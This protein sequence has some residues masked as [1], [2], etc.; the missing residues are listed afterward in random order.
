MR[1][2]ITVLVGLIIVVAAI[3]FLR[4]RPPVVLPIGENATSTTLEPGLRQV[5][6]YFPNT[7][8]DPETDCKTVFPVKRTVQDVP[9]IGR[10]SL[11][12]LL[13]GPTPAEKE[14][15]YYTSINP[16]VGIRGLT[17]SDGLA[18]VDFDAIMEKGVGGSCRV[19]SI[20]TQV[21]DTL[22]QF[23]SVRDVIISVE[24]RTEDAL[25]P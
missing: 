1:A 3:A 19:V 22:L 5:N 25:Q 20:R 11:L 16:D 18:R 9:G 14:Q 23:P 10:E 12:A 24:G 2:S 21:A 4:T 6:V 13:S 17:I 7:K 8:L 15:G